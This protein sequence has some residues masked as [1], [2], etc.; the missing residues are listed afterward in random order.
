[1]GG[2]SYRRVK[3]EP[4]TDINQSYILLPGHGYMQETSIFHL[5]SS[6]ISVK[7]TLAASWITFPYLSLQ[8]LSVGLTVSDLS[9]QSG[10]SVVFYIL[11][12]VGMGWLADKWGYRSSIFGNI[13]L[14][15]IERFFLLQK[16]AG[17]FT[18]PCYDNRL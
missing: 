14:K 6:E 2:E 5:D 11:S 16:C 1:M 10:L 17:A 12:A 9:Q 4:S 3:Y 8:T 7:I 15:S 13:M 18:C